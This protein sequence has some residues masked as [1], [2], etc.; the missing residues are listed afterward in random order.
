MNK[1][2][3]SGSVTVCGSLVKF[4]GETEWDDYDERFSHDGGSYYQPSHV[5]SWSE[6]GCQ[7]TLR[8]DNSSCG[9]FGARIYAQLDK[10][11][12]CIAQASYWSMISREFTDFD[13]SGFAWRVALAIAE[14]IGYHIPTLR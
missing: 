11:G 10:D 8:I 2:I 1:K 7:Y 14:S 5:V 13:N 4:A 3:F 12:C 6:N 9:D